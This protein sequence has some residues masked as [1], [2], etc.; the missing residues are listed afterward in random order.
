MLASAQGI[1]VDAAFQLLRRHA[2]DHNARIH[3]V[4]DAVVHL[5]LRPAP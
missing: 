1:S 3:D 5:G 2:R 4:A